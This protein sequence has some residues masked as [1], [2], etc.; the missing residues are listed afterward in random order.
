MLTSDA[1][2]LERHTT[3][4]DLWSE[5]LD[6]LSAHYIE[7]VIYIS[8]AADRTEPLVLTNMPEL[9]HDAAPV[10]DPFLEHCCNS[11]EIT[12][13]GPGYL[14]AHPYLSEADRSFV[15]RAGE[16]GFQSGLGI[17]MRLQ[18]STRFGGFNLGTGLDRSAFEAR[19]VP[20]QEEFRVFCLLL[21][22]KIEELMAD[23]PPRETEFRDL[24]ITPPDA[25]LA[26]L[27]PREREVIY[28][29]ARGLTRKECARHCGIS[30]HTVAEYTKSAYRKLGVTNRKDAAAKL[31][32]L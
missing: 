9:Y 32:Y 16:V 2:R 28:L 6:I 7:F 1:G 18:G 22:R 24:L 21:H 10:T 29:I 14:S 17:P 31:S 26:G 11:Y 20:K 27:S 15:E 23:T 30:P 13:T 4:R 5:A 8:V 12:H 3:I 19:I 25:Q